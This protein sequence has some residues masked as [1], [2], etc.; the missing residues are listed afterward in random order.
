MINIIDLFLHIDKNLIS[1]IAT[2]GN[3]TYL[4][5]FLIIFFETGIVLTPFFPGDSL[6]FA[7]GAISATKAINVL[8][9]FIVLCSAAILGD[10][11]N[12]FIGKFIGKR[13]LDKKLIK[14]EYITRT[15]KFYEKYGGKTII[16]ARF[17]PIVRTIA[18]FTAGIGKMEYSKFLFYNIIGGISWVTIFLF[19]GYYFGNIP[20][21]KTNLSIFL[22]LIIILSILPGIIE[23]IKHKSKKN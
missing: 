2:Y 3:F 4:F 1:L 22:I 9:L 7:I 6:I 18:P 14:R 11:A 23:Y 21:I 8:I 16:F 20:L 10:T 17:I 13:I 15:D 12:Y 5:M 19:S